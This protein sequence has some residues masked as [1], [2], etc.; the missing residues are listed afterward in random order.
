MKQTIIYLSLILSSLSYSQELPFEFAGC[1]ESDFV[2][3]TDAIPRITTN[4]AGYSPK[5]LKIVL[6][7]EVP[8]EVRNEVSISASL[9]HPLQ[10]IKN[11]SMQ[12]D[13]PFF[14]ENS[15]T[16]T[17]QKKFKE[18]GVYGYFCTNHGDSDGSGMA[19]AIW[20]VQ[21]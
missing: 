21:E 7:E 12:P 4:G 11:L 1:E 8:N 10:A 3:S 18:P 9:G 13:N 14:A 6:K 16:T 20:V 19:G 15:S 17:L 2:T 5:C